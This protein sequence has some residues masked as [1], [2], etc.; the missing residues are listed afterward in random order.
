[1]NNTRSSYWDNLKGV[2]IILVVFA[3]FLYSFT[4]AIIIDLIVYMIYVF[5]MPAFVFVSGH[6]THD[7]PKIR[8]LVSALIIFQGIYL[9]CAF[10]QLG[11]IDILAPAYICWYLVALI[12]WRLIARYIPRKIYTLP[13]LLLVSLIAGFIPDIGNRF[14]LMRIL[15]FMIFFTSGLFITE[16]TVLKIRKALF[17][18]FGIILI[19]AGIAGAL[20]A[21]VIFDYSKHDLTMMGYESMDMVV[22]RLV[23]LIL[24]FVFILGLIGVIPDTRSFMTVIG[25][26]SLPVFLLHRVLTFIYQW[27]F[28]EAGI[29]DYRIII[30]TSVIATV[31][32]I[33]AFGNDGFAKA[34]DSFLSSSDAKY[35][36]LR[37]LAEGVCAGFALL[38][39][40][41]VTVMDYMPEGGIFGNSFLNFGDSEVN[42]TRIY[43]VCTKEQEERINNSVRIV[44]A[45]DLV[46][47][48]DQ[49]RLAYDPV[50]GEYDFSPM[51]EY[52]EDTISSADLAIGVY[53][54]PSGGEDLGYSTSNYDD[55]LYVRTN[56]P[57]EFAY[58]ISDAGF[59]I[60]TTCNNHILDFGVDAA[61]RT[62]GV[63]D[64]AGLMHIGTYTDEADREQNRVRIVEVSG[65]RIAVLA[66]S[67]ASNYHTDEEF[68]DGEYSSLTSVIAAPGSPYYERSYQMVQDDFEYCRSLDPDLIIVLPHMGT[69]FSHEPDEF[70]ITWR[71]NFIDL[72]ADIILGDH[73]H[74]V[75]PAFMEEIGGRMTFTAYCPGHYCDVFRGYDGDASALVEVFIDPDTHGIIAGGII[76]MWNTAQANGN[77]RPIP[78]YDIVRDDSILSI[79]TVDDMEL[80]E[81]AN[82]VITENALGEPISIDN[83]EFDY[84][85]DENGFMRRRCEQLEMTG[86]IEASR[87]FE[88]VTGADSV[89]FIGDDVTEGSFNGGIPWYEPFEGYIAGEVT[90][91]SGCGWTT[92]DILNN[93]SLVPESSVY[94]V[95]AGVNDLHGTGL[96]NGALTSEEYIQNIEEID[97]ALSAIS[98]ECTVF[99]IA[100]WISYEEDRDDPELNEVTGQRRESYSEALAEFAGEY[101]I[102]PSGYINSTVSRLPRADYLLDYMHPN[103]SSGVRLYSEAVILS[104]N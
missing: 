86:E 87:F 82:A 100:P 69:M 43:R 47:L 35:R 5:H 4:D 2:L 32:V 13:L 52:T 58:A 96:Q 79:L 7:P 92:G 29:T 56:Y 41:F 61:L 18:L 75:Q 23:L 59:D 93:I 88:A 8:K 103:A 44:F 77:Y 73:T 24:A 54:G 36:K 76:P 84:L 78:I 70:Q 27:A 28:K 91:I 48:E 94:V 102:D 17:P 26:N 6:F 101:F 72:G 46:L 74:A 57:D 51:F 11:Y 40:L 12:V 64:D 37:H 9:L 55:N 10:L 21:R 62:N 63:L 99:Y 30:G 31:I 33:A 16:D 68:F 19:M 3:H 49:V 104:S 66:Y 25:R 80:V 83:V 60:V 14:A 85:F 65:M 53:E 38:A 50:S 97:A 22:G 34:F 39:F 95:A 42:G 1:M 81:Q 20:A 67:Y 90:N 71:Q 45:G 98:P 15:T 89:C